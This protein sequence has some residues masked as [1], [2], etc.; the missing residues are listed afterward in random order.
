M[1]TVLTGYL[2]PK[3]S[4]ENSNDPNELKLYFEVI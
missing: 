4:K 2:K 3:K 1:H